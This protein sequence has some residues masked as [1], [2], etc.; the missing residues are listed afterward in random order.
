MS[1]YFIFFI[2]TLAI[3]AS[4]QNLCGGNCPSANCPDCP[5]GYHPSYLS[6]SYWCSQYTWSQSCCLCIISRESGGNA[7]AN[8]YN[9]SSTTYDTGLFQVSSQ[10]WPYCGMNIWNSCNP[11]LGLAC[12]IQVYKWGSNTWKF[13]TTAAGCGC[14][15]SS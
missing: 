1:V 15:N 14:Q 8:N 10:N 4:A 3:S 12:A 11:T 6:A 9:P 5:C 13:W 2:F 7:N